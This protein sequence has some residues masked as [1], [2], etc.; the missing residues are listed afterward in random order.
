MISFE[1]NPSEKSEDSNLS[2]PEKVPTIANTSSTKKFEKIQNRK[3][4][5]A[6]KAGA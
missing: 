5:V 4:L 2:Y 1:T 3:R 6:G